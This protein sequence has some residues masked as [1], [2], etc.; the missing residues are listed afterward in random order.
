MNSLCRYLLLI[1]TIVSFSACDHY[2][3]SI[4]EHHDKWTADITV[5]SVS[6]ESGGGPATLVSLTNPI[7]IPSTVDNVFRITLQNEY[8]HDFTF[9]FS[10]SGDSPGNVTCGNTLEE[11]FTIT[12]AAV[13]DHYNL[14]LTI[15]MQTPDGGNYRVFAFNLPIEC[16][17]TL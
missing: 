2:G 13:G 16:T 9:S 14:T 4:G 11:A 3:L 8:Q 1:F 10:A 7:S 6:L 12:G 15:T 17:F 5:V